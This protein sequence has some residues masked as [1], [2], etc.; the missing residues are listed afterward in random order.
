[1]KKKKSTILDVAHLAN[2]SVATVSRVV[3]K[4]GGVKPRTEEKIVE[5]I[6]E[7]G[8]VR[9]AIARSMVRQETKTIGV[10]IPD[11]TNPFFSRV[12]SGIEREAVRCG[13]Q[14]I[15][16]SSQDS[17]DIERNVL[18]NFLERG[19]DGLIITTSNEY[20]Q[21][22]ERFMESD[23]PV[24][25]VDRQLHQ[26]EVD[27]VL[28]GNREGAYEAI[29]HLTSRGFRKIAIIRG[30]QS[31]TPG[32][33]RYR[34]YSKALNDHGIEIVEDWIVDG[35]FGEESGYQAAQTLYSLEDRPDAVFSSNN[36][37]SMGA[38]KAMNELQWGIGK[39][40][41]F[42]GFDDIEISTFHKPNLTKSKRLHFR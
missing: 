17:E 9:N 28:S 12:I 8:Y 38:L 16:S 10:L 18:D 29:R 36:L 21:H 6:A 22:L 33:E 39:D 25:A 34:G 15:L 14:T 31:T 41:G 23:I 26:Y 32:L 24:V 5:A 37:M 20:G 35:D 42:V 1:V 3:N 40:L 30:P 7:L 27:T 11:I 13:Y 19:I 2:V 4:Q